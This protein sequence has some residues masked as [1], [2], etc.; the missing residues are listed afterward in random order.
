MIPC[1]RATLMSLALLGGLAAPAGAEPPPCPPDAMGLCG[2]QSA[3][4]R[5]GAD[6][7]DM[8]RDRDTTDAYLYGEVQQAETRPPAW[9]EDFDVDA[10]LDIHA[11]WNDPVERAE[12]A[13][14]PQAVRRYPAARPAPAKPS[15]SSAAQYRLGEQLIGGRYVVIRDAAAWGLARPPLGHYYVRPETGPVL[16]VESASQRIRARIDAASHRDIG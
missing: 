15:A 1:P 7:R 9:D 5:G 10:Y 6:H 14:D 8:R 16:L 13:A 3:G 12:R 2:A 4:W 11:G